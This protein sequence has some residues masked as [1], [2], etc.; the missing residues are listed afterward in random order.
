MRSTPRLPRINRTA[1]R[2]ATEGRGGMRKSVQAQESLILSQWNLHL[3]ACMSVQESIH[4]NALMDQRP[5]SDLFYS[6]IVSP[7]SWYHRICILRILEFLVCRAKKCPISLSC[8][9][10]KWTSLYHKRTKTHEDPC[11]CLVYLC[12]CWL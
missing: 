5:F 2:I 1:L 8:L 11:Y 6:P 9:E 3:Q 10:F 4:L 7:N 12:C